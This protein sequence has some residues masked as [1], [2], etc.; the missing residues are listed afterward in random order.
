MTGRQKIERLAKLLNSSVITYRAA[1][2]W[3]AADYRCVELL[4][5]KETFDELE[6][7]VGVE[8]NGRGGKQYEGKR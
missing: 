1:S 5:E 3:G 6:R 2:Y 4:M 8:I 7:F